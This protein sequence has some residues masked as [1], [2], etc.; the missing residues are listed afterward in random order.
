M[1]QLSNSTLDLLAQDDV[2]QSLSQLERG[3]EKESLRIQPNGHLAQTPHPQGLGSALTHGEITTDYAEALLEFITPTYNKVDDCLAHLNTIHRYVYSQLDNESLW[4]ASMPCILGS[5]DDIPVAQYGD[6]N[7]GQM[8]TAYRLGLGHRYGRLMQTIAGVH[9]N[10]SFPDAFWLQ[11]QKQQ[12]AEQ[13][14]LSLQ[15]FKTQQYFHLIRNF[16]R[17]VWLLIYLFGASPAVCKSFVSGREHKLEASTHGTLSLPYATALRMGNLGYQ[18]SA[19]DSLH[20]SYNNL[21]EYTECLLHALIDTHPE[22]ESIGVKVDGQYKQLSTA[23][24]QIENEFYSVVRPKRTAKSGETPINALN[25]RG[26]E[27]IEVRCLDVNPFLPL[28]I[29]AEQLRFVDTFLLY[30]L[31]TPSPDLDEQEQAQASAN[32]ALVVEQGRAP[33]LKLSTPEGEVEL[34]KLAEQMLA[35]MAAISQ[36][37]DKYNAEAN[38]LELGLH[39]QALQAQQQ[40]LVQPELLPSAQ[41]MQTIKDQDI[42]Y[43]RFA[44][45][46]AEQHKDDFQQNPLAT[47]Q[48]R[49]YE[50]LA[51]SSLSAQKTLESQQEIDFDQYLADYYQQYKQLSPV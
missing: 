40:K 4:T 51:T 49:H 41:I 44:M 7:V 32:Q 22:Y 29:D 2:A 24:L 39:Q 13:Q 21:E 14:A 48:Q 37:Q 10:V 35:G 15:D 20:V 33:N 17:H 12:P 5:D 50:D 47:E 6:S 28:G 36:S 1:T 42:P 27:Y 23:L 18:S 45:N 11:Y 8:K 26:V 43:F 38:D 16:R 31:L 3:L 9:Y 34:V 46:L 30:C 19:Q 25:E